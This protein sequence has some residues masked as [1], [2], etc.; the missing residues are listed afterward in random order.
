MEYSQREA[1]GGR[2]KGMGGRGG[3][4]GGRSGMGGGRGG[5]GGGRAGSIGNKS[6]GDRTRPQL[7]AALDVS[8]QLRLVDSDNKTD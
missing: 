3:I 2:M 7:A 5:K 6:P 8:L 1:G 4:G